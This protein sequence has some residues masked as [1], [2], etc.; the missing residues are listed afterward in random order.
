MAEFKIVIN[1]VKTGKTYQKDLSDE[2]LIGKKIGDKVNG[3]LIGLN[4]Y[5]LEI[6]GGSDSAGFP[7]HKS[8]ESSG[9]KKALLSGAPG[10]HIKR[11]GMKARKTIRGNVISD[12]VVQINMK[13]VKYGKEKLEKLLGL[14]PEE[15]P[16]EE[17][18]AEEKTSE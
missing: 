11:K 7:M 13:I 3:D 16:K 12:Q 10:V 6:T 9:R 1:D 2:S 4:G 18:K 14:E 5:E 15:T 8:L 17:V